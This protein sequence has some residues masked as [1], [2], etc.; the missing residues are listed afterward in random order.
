[1]P[2]GPLH[3]ECPDCDSPIEHALPPDGPSDSTWGDVRDRLLGADVHC[4]RC[5]NSIGVYVFDP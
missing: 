2:I 3:V 5:G 1:M 4:D